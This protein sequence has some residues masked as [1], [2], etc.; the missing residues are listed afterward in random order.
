GIFNLDIVINLNIT[1]GYNTWAFFGQGEYSLVFAVH[2]HGY[3]FEVKED[4]NNIL[5]NTF[6]IAVLVQYT[7]DLHFCYGTT[8]HRGKQDT[9]QCIAKRMTKTTLQWLQHNT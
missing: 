1:S 4:F 8:G 6:N 3:T 7:V 2:N 5:A 9:T